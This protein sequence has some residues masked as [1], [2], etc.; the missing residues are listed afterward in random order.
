[1]KK[2]MIAAA[3]VCAAAFSQA[4]TVKWVSDTMYAPTA[5]TGVYNTSSKISTGTA[6]MYNITKAQ[7]DT[8]IAALVSDQASAM[9]DI[10]DTV[11]TGTAIGSAAMSKNKWTITDSRDVSAA[12]GSAPIDLYSAIIYTY[13]DGDGKDWYVANVATQHFEMDSASQL[14]NLSSKIGGDPTGVSITGWQTAAV[15]EP[16]S[17]LLLV[18]GIA[19]LALKRR[20]A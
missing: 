5:E 17:G 1:M 18:L 2:I 4:A 6:S 10:Y 16:T 9:K 7:Y 8:W 19:G 12:T 11:S 3:V 13:T 14:G 15:P 20:R